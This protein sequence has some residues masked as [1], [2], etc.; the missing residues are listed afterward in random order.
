MRKVK[1]LVVDDH[2]IVWDGL[3]D[4]AM[5]IEYIEEKDNDNHGIG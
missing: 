5:V 1:V 4:S 2:T 3:G